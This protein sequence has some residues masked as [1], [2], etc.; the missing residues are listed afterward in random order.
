MYTGLMM[1]SASKN[2]GPVALKR[3]RFSK[4]R[5]ERRRH[6]VEEEKLGNHIFIELPK[7]ED[8]RQSSNE[9][10]SY[11]KGQFTSKPPFSNLL[12]SA[13]SKLSFLSVWERSGS[14]VE[15]LTRDREAA[16]SSLTGVTALWSLSKPHLF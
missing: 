15:C 7:S 13:L 8:T 11:K 12:L 14:V 3:G 10:Y 4:R 6:L 1:V 9:V 2:S 16:G 5:E